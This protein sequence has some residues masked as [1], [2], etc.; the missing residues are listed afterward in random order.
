MITHA[1]CDR[2]SANRLVACRKRLARA[3]LTLLEV[4][5]ALSIFVLSVMAIFQ[6]VHGASDLALRL[7]MEA[8]ASQLCQAKMAEIVAG[9]IPLQ[10]QS[11]ESMDE[12]PA[13]EWSMVCEPRTDL[14]ALWTVTV[15]VER[16]G[17]GGR[18]IEARLTQFVLDPSQ[19]GGKQSG[20]SSPG[21]N[22]SGFGSSSGSGMSAGGN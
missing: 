16:E 5:I 19:R 6:L 1:N 3:G 18:Q 20:A 12:D 13:W 14:P 11:G 15:R 2:H 9:V 7:Q 22:G 8:R 21:A 17:P 4:I 10:S